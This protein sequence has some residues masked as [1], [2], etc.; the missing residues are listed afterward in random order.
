MKILKVIMRKIKVPVWIIMCVMIMTQG[1]M[2]LMKMAKGQ[3]QKNARVDQ[4]PKL[5]DEEL[6]HLERRRSTVQRDDLLLKEAKDD[7]L[8][9]KDMCDA[10]R[11]STVILS[12]SV[13]G[14]GNA[15]NNIGKGIC[16][17]IEVLAYAFMQ[18]NQHQP[19]NQNLFYQNDQLF[20]YPGGTQTY[21][22]ND[23][24]QSQNSQGSYGSHISQLTS[25]TNLR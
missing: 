21:Q 7:T 13:K 1:M 4:V 8:L 19:I 5:V 3:L 23:N 2:L 17:S 10:M 11:E 9:K 24:V 12:E 20:H 15:M 25:H 14:I 18:P 6:K 22:R 16:R